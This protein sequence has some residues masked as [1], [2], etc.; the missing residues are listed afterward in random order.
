MI[1]ADRQALGDIGTSERFIRFTERA[2]PFRV[3]TA[4]EMLSVFRDP[5][6]WRLYWQ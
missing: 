2:V 4:S 6:A 1:E 5:K 3:A